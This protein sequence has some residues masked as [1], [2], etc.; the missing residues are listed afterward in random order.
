MLDLKAPELQHFC[1]LEV[2]VGTVRPLG[3]GR[4]GQ[5]RIIPIT[6]GRVSGP[7]LNGRILPGGADWMTV[8]HDGVA[9][10]DA[11]YSFETDDGA[12]IEMIDQGFRHGPEDVMRRLVAGEPVSPGDYYM[13]SSIRLETG[14]KDYAFIN[15]MVFVGTG[16][17]TATGV[18]VNI[19]SVQ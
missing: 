18:Q 7:R 15:R 16:A 9:Q 19:Y 13:R 14:H 3:M 17:K 12:I 1:T 2:E 5:R 11:R 4:L 8:S 6:G 10:M